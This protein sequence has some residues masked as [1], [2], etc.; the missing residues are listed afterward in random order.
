M[1]TRTTLFGSIIHPWLASIESIRPYSQNLEE[2][3]SLI[4]IP[5]P[6]VVDA[7]NYRDIIMERKGIKF[8]TCEFIPHE[9]F[10][11][12]ATARIMKQLVDK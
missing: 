11:W 4:F 9:E 8:K 7:R 12:G 5:M 10:V 2:V 3:T 6:L 1:E